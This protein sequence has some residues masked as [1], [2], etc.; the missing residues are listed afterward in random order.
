MLL[1]DRRG[2]YEPIARVCIGDR[3]G[4]YEPIAS[5][6]IDSICQHLAAK[7]EWLECFPQQHVYIRRVGSEDEPTIMIS[8]DAFQI[9]NVGMLQH[10]LA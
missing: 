3:R 8:F 7:W 5:V 10:H 1:G 2:G 4:G 9:H 6:Y